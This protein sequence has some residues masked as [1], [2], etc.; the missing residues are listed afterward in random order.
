V[1]AVGSTDG[2]GIVMADEG[3][4]AC[5]LVRA[6]QQQGWHPML[7]VP[8]Q[9]GVSL[10]GRHRRRSHRHASAETW[11]AMEGERSVE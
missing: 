4:D 5:W 1:A 8:V 9:R 6:I 10:P 11:A 7:R 3:L 2:K